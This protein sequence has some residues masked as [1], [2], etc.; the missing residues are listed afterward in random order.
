MKGKLERTTF[1]VS[2]ELEF[3]SEK[4][5][6][7]QIGHGKQWWPVAILKEL[8]DNAL[9]ACETANIAP[10]IEITIDENGFSVRDNGP[11][12]PAETLERSLDYFKRVSDKTFY[13]SP[14]RGQL[15]N[16][17]KTVWAAPFVASGEHGLVEVWSQ[18][19]HHIVEVSIDRIAQRP[20][21]EH[22]NEKDGVVKNGTLVYVQWKN[23][24]C[25]IS[26]ILTDFYNAPPP[27]AQE[28]VEGY[29]VFNPHATFTISNPEN[30]KATFVATNPEWQ[31]WKPDAPTSAHW[32]TAETLRDLIAAY[33]ACERES[34]KERTVREFVS[35]FRGLSS[36][37]K[38]K[39]ITDGLSGVFLH[40]LVSDGDIDM[41]IVEKLLVA[42]QENSKPPSP[43]VLGIISQEHIKAWLACY[44]G[45][46][47]ESIRYVKRTGVEGNMPYI[48]EVTFG[49]CG[50]DDAKLRIVTGLNWAP[51]LGVP[52]SDL[53]SV[54]SEMR[55]DPHDPVTLLVHLAK[56]RF[57]F[58]NR[59]KSEVQL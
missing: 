36:T 6:Q 59:G 14:T 58:T 33:V 10:E 29:A 13:V 51:T 3:F 30:G 21:I 32:Y 28:L 48:I 2:R 52:S 39:Q 57:D 56:P 31:K 5:L 22:S 26:P 17:L 25:L 50:M 27:T 46:T 49:V 44:A 53:R 40:D 55:I 42:M 34:G 8:I 15:G 20:V 47:E 38:Q 54:I 12:L 11:G 4:E 18:G 24:S 41:R 16:A 7:M 43:S 35:E 45:V 23:S 1:E 37:A 9:D 19:L